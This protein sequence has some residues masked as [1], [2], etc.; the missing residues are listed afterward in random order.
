MPTLRRP[1]FTL[2]ELLVVIAIIAI[3]AA[4]LLPTLRR[5]RWQAERTACL[6]NI[7]QLYLGMVNYADDYDGF[8]PYAPTPPNPWGWCN[9]ESGQDVFNSNWA[10]QGVPSGW[11]TFYHLDYVDIGV[12]KCPAARTSN[13][14]KDWKGQNGAWDTMDPTSFPT[15]RDT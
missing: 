3:L 5:A 2:I 1:R 13:V 8:T 11:Y 10:G 4:M 6:N 9:S 12:V 7:R 14:V 15:P